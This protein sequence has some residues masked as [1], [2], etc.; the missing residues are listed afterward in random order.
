[1]VGFRP[2]IAASLE[3][4]A[5]R[6][7]TAEDRD[8]ERTTMKDAIH[9]KYVACKVICGCGNTFATR[10]TRSEITVEICGACHPFYSG[11]QKFVD[12]AG[13]VERFMK[14]YANASSK[15]QAKA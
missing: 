5:F 13:R 14:R 6:P 9:P 12:T 10:S 1:M 15:P 8:P 11:K 3:V 7:D 2:A 4:G